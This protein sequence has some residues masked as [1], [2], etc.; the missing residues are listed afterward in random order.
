MLVST[1]NS[2]VSHKSEPTNFVNVEKL[3]FSDF[4]CPYLVLSDS[5]SCTLQFFLKY[6]CVCARACACV[7]VHAHVPVCAADVCPVRVGLEV[8]ARGLLHHIY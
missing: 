4:S 1:L 2:T 5:S 3:F 6:V 8:G 7:L